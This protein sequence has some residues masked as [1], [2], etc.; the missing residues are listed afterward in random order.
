[1]SYNRCFYCQWIQRDL[2][3]L[4]YFLFWG[5]CQYIL[6]CHLYDLPKSRF[7][8]VSRCR[9]WTCVNK[10]SGLRIKMG[11][12]LKIIKRN[13]VL[14]KESIFLNFDHFCA[15]KNPN[16]EKFRNKFRNFANVPNFSTDYFTY[17]KSSFFIRVEPLIQKVFRRKERLLEK[18]HTKF[19]RK[20]ILKWSECC[21]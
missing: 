21:T 20:M 15:S 14:E 8:L 7:K 18:S 10:H 19:S 2:Q 13:K 16:Q 5:D 4:L 17:F 9:I 1:M 6:L 12:N 11:N 3:W